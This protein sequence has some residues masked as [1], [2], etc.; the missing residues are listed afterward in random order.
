MKKFS[1]EISNDIFS[2]ERIR[3]KVLNHYG[4]ENSNITIIKFKDTDKQRIVFKIT[5][6]NKFYI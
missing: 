5:Y 3:H 4:L 1:D 6:K 2:E